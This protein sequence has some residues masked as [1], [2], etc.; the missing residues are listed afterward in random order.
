MVSPDV[1]VSILAVRMED[2]CGRDIK[3]A[4]IDAAVRTAVA[5][6]ACVTLDDLVAAIERVKPARV[7]TE[8]RPLTGEEAAE[9][10]MNILDVLEKESVE[11]VF[12]PTDAPRR[13][14]TEGM[15]DE[16]N[17]AQCLA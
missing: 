5:D 14:I 3:N 13:V 8:Q 9:A 4:V 15:P 10:R 1:D 6:R 12:T 17:S 11:E 7:T 2:V 16:R